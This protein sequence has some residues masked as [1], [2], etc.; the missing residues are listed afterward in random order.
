LKETISA[1]RFENLLSRAS[2]AVSPRSV[3]FNPY[4]ALVSTAGQLA[5]SAVAACRNESLFCATGEN[6]TLLSN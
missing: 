2:S 3:S 6:P 1:F 5:D 4:A